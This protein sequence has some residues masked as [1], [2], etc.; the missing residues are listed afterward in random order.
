MLR[1]GDGACGARR[2]KLQPM[3]TWMVLLVAIALAGCA[4]PVLLSDR[5]ASVRLIDAAAAKGCTFLK[6]VAYT[7]TL[8]GTGKTP[9]LVH[10]DGENGIRDAVAT[11]GGNAFISVQADADWFFG[12]VNYTAE[13][14]RC[15]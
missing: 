5:G 9:G 13:A 12:H 11:A 3:K 14:Y 6:S 2:A 7:N 15:P 4:T 1:I 8:Y 10:Q